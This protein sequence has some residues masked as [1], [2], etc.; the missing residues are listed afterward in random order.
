M[1]IKALAPA[2]LALMV[3]APGAAFAEDA[4]KKNILVFGDSIAWGWVPKA[5]IVPTVR[6]APEDRWP[7]VL[8]AELG[9]G[10]HII[11]EGLS[12]RTTNVD[13]PTAEGLMDGAEYLDSALV[14]HEQLDL[15]IVML[16][17]NDTK[18]Y[19]DRTPFEIGLGM[20]ELI[21][22][23]QD[24]SGLGWYEYEV[25]TPEILIISPPPLGDEVD[26]LATEMF[27]GAQDKISQLSPIYQAIA[28]AAGVHFYDAAVVVDPEE[29]GVDGIHLIAKGNHDLGR[30]IANKVK[31]INP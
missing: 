30:A 29:V 19:F 7:N 17:T 28:E 16:G 14:S 4:N 25:D 5:P 27:A 18:S 13:D 3:A 20:G 6:H 23:I 10:Y 26:P 11:T 24:G 2:A 9:D 22:V 15:V 21:S 8:Q 12:G 31:A 1:Q